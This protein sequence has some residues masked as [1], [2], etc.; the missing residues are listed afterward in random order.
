MRLGGHRL[1][2]VALSQGKYKVV[3]QQIK[4]DI[5]RLY[6]WNDVVLKTKTPVGT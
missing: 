2:P 6:A 3:H 1:A 5:T 4:I